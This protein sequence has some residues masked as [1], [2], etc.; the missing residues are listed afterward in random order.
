MDA[1]KS[2]KLGFK[3]VPYPLVYISLKIRRN[4]LQTGNANF[5]PNPPRKGAT[6]ENVTIKIYVEQIAINERW[7]FHQSVRY[8]MRNGEFWSESRIE[9]NVVQCTL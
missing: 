4:I 1:C 9:S 3:N 8:L 7:E 6:T 5:T 2:H